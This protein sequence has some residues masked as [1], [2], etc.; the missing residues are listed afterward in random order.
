MLLESET[1]GGRSS[2]LKVARLSALAVLVTVGAALP[3]FFL[4]QPTSVAGTSVQHVV[5]GKGSYSDPVFNPGGTQIAFVSNRTGGPS[6]V[7]LVAR[8]GNH[9]TM[10]TSSPGDKSDPEWNSGGTLIAFLSSN[11][12]H[13]KGLWVMKA[14]GSGARLISKVDETVGSFSWNPRGSTIAYDSNRGGRWSVWSID[15]VDGIRSPIS[16]SVS[17]DSR[18]PSWSPDGNST[19]YSSNRYGSF[20]VFMR[21][22]VSG[23]EQRVTALQGENTFPRLNPDGKSI[24][25]LS[26]RTGSWSLFVTSL[27]GTEFTNLLGPYDMFREPAWSPP[28]DQSANAR[29]NPLGNSVLFTSSGPAGAMKD[30]YLLQIRVQLRADE[31]GTFAFGI[32]QTRVSQNLS[33]ANSGAWD[34]T[35]TVIALSSVGSNGEGIWTIQLKPVAPGSPYG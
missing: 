16:A 7:W 21:N 11:G 29:W 6:Q 12:S 27:N 1:N 22:L 32:A 30:V 13:S 35:G 33:S 17:F 8:A 9:L 26:N 14:D 25:L 31:L 4:P 20:D 19:V 2:P 34:R 24:L 28:V 3:L 23:S 15:A 10:L 5:A 18:Y